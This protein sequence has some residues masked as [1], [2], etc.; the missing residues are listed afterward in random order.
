MSAFCT[1]QFTNHVL[2]NR[3]SFIPSL[4]FTVR[5]V[6]SRVPKSVAKSATHLPTTH[7][8]S[9]KRQR[10]RTCPRPTILARSVSEGR[11]CPR[12]A[13]ILDPFLEERDDGRNLRFCQAVSDQRSAKSA[14]AELLQVE[15]VVEHA[16]SSSD[17]A[18]VPITSQIL[19]VRQ[20]DVLSQ[21]FDCFRQDVLHT[22]QL[23]GVEQVRR[24]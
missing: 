10:G 1:S 23:P 3:H 20:H 15:G 16:G 5:E 17:V 2:S 24:P 7:H 4:L 11:T 6:V 18:R 13:T 22:G 8:P 14:G 12:P 9:P 21:E 19:G